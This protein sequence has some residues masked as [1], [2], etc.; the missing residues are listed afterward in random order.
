MEAK[1]NFFYIGEN[2][3]QYVSWAKFFIPGEAKMFIFKHSK[4]NID[5]ASFLLS[6]PSI[7]RKIFQFYILLLALVCFNSFSVESRK[8][9][10]DEIHLRFLLFHRA[11]VILSRWKIP[12]R[13]ADLPLAATF[14]KVEKVS[15]WDENIKDAIKEK[16]DTGSSHTPTQRKYISMF[17]SGR[18]YLVQCSTSSN[19]LNFISNWYESKR[20][21]VYK[22]SDSRSLC[23]HPKKAKKLNTPPD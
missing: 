5:F 17:D 13:F 10:I 22:F 8:T 6:A 15:R 7:R 3:I 14:R 21:F 23:R 9:I 16:I 12:K 11:F 18:E 19:P 20:I 4:L 1:W 2:S